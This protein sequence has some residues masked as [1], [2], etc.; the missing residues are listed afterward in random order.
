MPCWW[1]A[2]KVVGRSRALLR[3]TALSGP[4]GD[5]THQQDFDLLNLQE[6][7]A[8]PVLASIPNPNTHFV[9]NADRQIETVTRPDGTLLT[10]TYDSAGRLD[11]LTTPTGSYDYQYYGSATCAGCAPGRTSRIVGPAGVTLDLQYDGSLLKSVT[12]S[13][14]VSGALSYAYDSDFRAS[15]QTLTV[16]GAGYPMSYGF[17][18]DSLVTCISPTN[19]ATPGSDALRITYDPAIARVT[20]SVLGG[21]TE[22]RTYNDYGEL[23]SASASTGTTSLYSETMDTPAAPRDR[24]GRIVT[25]TESLLGAGSTREY[26]YDARGRLEDVFENGIQVEHY[27]YDA[28]GNRLS[29]VTPSETLSGSYDAQDRLLSYGPYVYTYTPNGEL[30]TKTDTRN[31]DLTTYTYDARGNLIRVEQPNGDVIEYVVDGLD[32]RVAKRKNGAVVRRWLYGDKLRIV[33]ELDGSGALIGRFVYGTRSNV[34]D[35][36]VRGGNTYR[37]LAD[38]LGSPR[39]VV[40]VAN[41]ADR[42]IV[43]R[44]DAFGESLPGSTGA[45][46]LPMGFAGGL[47]DAETGLVRFGARDYDAYTGRWTARDPSLFHGGDA[48]LH[49]YAGSDPVNLLD[50]TGKAPVPGDRF[51]G[52]GGAAV[53]GGA[54]LG[55]GIGVGGGLAVGA[56]AAGVGWSLG[57]L[58]DALCDM[59][60]EMNRTI[61][62]RTRARSVGISV[63]IC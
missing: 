58:V 43:I 30:R 41:A 11:L 34:P 46:W 32:R 8:P 12:W 51:D 1:V 57:G 4:S 54:G 35:F 59:F 31:G 23:A 7:Y 33:A 49:A 62:A 61:V 44:H 53:G 42:P 21:M 40:N 25:H 56:G 37:V 16:G 29:K 14:A 60:R 50:R 55:N 10:F 39:V 22:T 38:H 2:A 36:V 6:T 20:Q 18:A 24:L 15:T 63:S 17:D 26:R 13:G 52:G 48:N 9:H 45:E 27:V 5:P 28:N 47:Y 3:H 19:C